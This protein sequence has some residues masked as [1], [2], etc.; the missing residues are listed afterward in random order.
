MKKLKILVVGAGL[1]GKQHIRLIKENKDCELAGI[2]E[3]DNKVSHL[4]AKE[5]NT[6]IYFS[7]DSYLKTGTVDGVIIA[8]PNEFHFDQALFCIQNQIP[9]LIEKPIASTVKSALILV[10]LAEIKK[11][12]VLVGHHR[13][14]SPF[15]SETKKII[16]SGQLGKLVS[17]MGSSQFYKPD[18]Y[19]IEGPWRKEIGG[20]PILINLI[21]DIGNLRLICGEIE[22][23]QAISSSAIRQFSVEDTL[24]VSFLFESGTLG[25]FLLSDTAASSLSWEHTSGENPSFPYHKNENCYF[26]SGTRGSLNIPS[27]TLKFYKNSDKSSW[28]NPLTESVLKIKRED[29]LTLQLKHFIDLIGSDHIRP[30]V[31]ALDGLRNLQVA[32]AIKTSAKLNKLIK[33]TY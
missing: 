33:I 16:Q 4:V 28:L 31:S 19:F 15:I 5:N 6:Q 30:M 22:A 26:V 27:M 9:V 10:N 21:H 13:V 1:M 24:A 25:S 14:Y 7:I 8:S 12:K 23:V 20:G 3:L 2:V 17:I 32:E 11:N 29:P 18:N